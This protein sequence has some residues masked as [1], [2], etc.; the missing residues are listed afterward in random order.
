MTQCA[1]ITSCKLGLLVN[2][3]KM[4][5]HYS[6]PLMVHSCIGTKPLTAGCSSGLSIIFALDYITQNLLS[7]KAALSLVPINHE[8]LTL[9]YFP[10]SIMSL[11]YN[12]KASKYLMHLD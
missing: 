12:M 7:S 5:L 9:T 8:I 10:H 1:R 2:L 3:P 11:L 4:T 6:F